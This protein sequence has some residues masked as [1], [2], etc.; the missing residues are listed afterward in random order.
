MKK[1][2]RAQSSV[3]FLAITGIGLLLITTVAAAFLSY[4][5]DTGDQVALK[6]VNDIGN[7]ILGQ[8]STVYSWG[9]YSWVSVDAVLPD[10]IVA[11]YT[12]ENNT[13][14]FEVATQNG[15]VAQPIFSTTPITGVNVVGTRAHLNNGTMTIHEGATKFRI[16]SLGSI[17]Q[18]QAVS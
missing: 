2:V 7:T 4:T 9:G 6:Q 3:E 17:V 11:I 13:L 16:T 10:S 8:A 5:R 12:T 1:Q 14:V 18:I 15:I